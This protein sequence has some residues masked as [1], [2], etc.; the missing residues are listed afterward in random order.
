MLENIIVSAANISLMQ[1]TRKIA[2][3]A[4]RKI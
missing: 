4:D 1:H 2:L 3:I